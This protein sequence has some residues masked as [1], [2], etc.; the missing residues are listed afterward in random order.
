MNSIPEKDWKVLRNS[1]EE[2]L[3]FACDNIFKK[4]DRISQSRVDNEHASY[5]ELW[6]IIQTENNKIGEMFDD[7][8]RSNALFKLVSMRLYG[9]LSD[10]Y[11]YKFS[12][13]TQQ[14]VL[15]LLKYRE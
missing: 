15:E 8:K 2:L 12:A 14:Q 11:L 1:K 4:V 6:Q 3:A 13:E 9:I 5:I 7:L 10:E